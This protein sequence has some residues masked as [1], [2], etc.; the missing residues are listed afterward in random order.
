[1]KGSVNPFTARLDS[2]QT[3]ISPIFVIRHRSE[4]L[5]S[6]ILNPFTPRLYLTSATIIL[7]YLTIFI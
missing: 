3:K 5:E 4:E 1:M 2:N 6:V 7:P